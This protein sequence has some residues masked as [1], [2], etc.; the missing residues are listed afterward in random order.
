M[1]PGDRTP[2]A[3]AGVEGL[4]VKL[5]GPV[6]GVGAAR[7]SMTATCAGGVPMLVPASEVASISLAGTPIVLDGVVQPITDAL[8][9]ALGALVEVRLNEV[10]DLGNG[11]RLV[12]AARVTLIRG[13][14]PLAEVIVAES[15]LGLNGAACD[16]SAAGNPPTPIP[17][18]CPEGSVYDV[19]RNLCVIP[20]PGSPSPTN[21]VG[22]ITGPGSVIVG[23]PSGGPSGGTVITL[24]EAK[25]RFPKSPCVKGKGPRYV[26]LGSKGRDRITGTNRRDRVLGRGGSDRIDGGRGGDCVDGGTA[27][28]FVTGGQGNDR[29]YGG[30]ARDIVNGDG[31][32]D[33]LSGGRGHD[34]LNAAY[35]RDRVFGGAGNDKINVAT[36]GRR[37]TVWAGPGRDKVRANPRELKRIHGA[38]IVKVTRPL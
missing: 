3:A 26:V 37:A 14:T 17:P 21:P 30:R 32:S 16:P 33:R 10:V 23:P 4:E 25:R 35:G 5:G 22:D 31:G 8:S 36:A 34:T 27:K 29:M 20:A 6:L 24:I 12:R 28:D 18:V 13:T 15:R 19:S 1:N 11:G 38:E 2:S 9:D 7:S